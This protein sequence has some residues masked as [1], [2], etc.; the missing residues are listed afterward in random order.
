MLS[1]FFMLA[2]L[3]FLF[4]L[5]DPKSD[6]PGSR[7]FYGSFFLVLFAI[8]TY[9]TLKTE[10]VYIKSFLLTISD[11]EITMA[12]EIPFSSYHSGG[13]HDT[14]LILTEQ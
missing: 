10:K 5:T 8:N 12:S 14:G 1:A 9:R 11:K 13:C 4:I 6:T 7:I 3:F 2:P